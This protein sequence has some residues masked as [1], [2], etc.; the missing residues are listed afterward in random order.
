MAWHDI[1]I[2]NVYDCFLALDVLVCIHFMVWDMKCMYVFTTKV[3]CSKDIAK[4]KDNRHLCISKWLCCTYF[5]N[6]IFISKTLLFIKP[7]IDVIII[8]CRDYFPKSWLIINTMIFILT[9]IVESLIRPQLHRL[10]CR[11]KDSSRSD[12]KK[13]SL[14]GSQGSLAYGVLIW[15]KLVL[16]IAS[17]CL[18]WHTIMFNNKILEVLVYFID[19]F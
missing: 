19:G 2:I 4:E 14:W 6:Y 3:I 15:D 10:W 5:I 13:R 12:C 7:I 18:M 8:T 1:W 11:L 17:L 16:S 9:E